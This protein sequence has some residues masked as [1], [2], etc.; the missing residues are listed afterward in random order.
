M[1]RPPLSSPLRAVLAG[2]LALSCLFGALALAAPATAAAP[3]LSVSV[4]V[5]PTVIAGEDADYTIV[6]TNGGDATAHSVT[7]SD[8]FPSALFGVSVTSAPPG[9]TGFPCTLTTLPAGA[10]ATFTV[11]ATVD[12][13]YAGTSLTNTAEISWPSVAPDQIAGSAQGDGDMTVSHLAD[14]AVTATPDRSGVRVGED[15]TWTVVAT[16]EGPSRGAPSLSLPVPAGTVLVGRTTPPGVSCNAAGSCSLGALSVGAQRIIEMTVTV[17]Q[18]YAGTS[19]TLVA[20]GEDGTDTTPNTANDTATSAVDVR[21]LADLTVT[22]LGPTTAV[23]GTSATWSLVVDNHGPSAAPDVSINQQ[24]PAGVTVTAVSG[25]GCNALPCTL[26]T[27]PKDGTATITVTAAI[28]PGF[29]GATLS[30]TATIA[31]PADEPGGAPEGGR[32]STANT[33]ITTSADVRVS[34]A[35]VAAPFVA[36]DTVAWDVVVT[37]DGP[38]TARDLVIVHN[39]PA[40]VSGIALSGPGGVTCPPGGPCTVAAIAPG[41]GNA[42]TIRVT[43]TLA[44]D[45]ADNEISNSVS[46]TSTTTDPD[47]ANNS[48]TA[49]VSVATSADLAVTTSGPSGTVLAGETISWTVTVSNSGPSDARGVVIADPLPSSITGVTVTSANSPCAAVPCTLDTL[50]PG[51]VATLQIS[52]TVAPSYAGA[53]VANTATVSSTTPDS[54]PANNMATAVTGIVRSADLSI[55]KTVDQ[56]PVVPGDDLTYTVTIIN[57]GP[58]QATAVTVT[59]TLPP[60]LTS[61]TATSSIGSCDPVTGVILTCTVAALDPDTS[62][63][64]TITGTLDP[65]VDPGTVTNSATVISAT[66]DPDLSDNTSQVATSTA[67]ADLAVA[68]TA[69]VAEVAP[70][71]AITWTV[72]VS[73]A[74][75]GPARAAVLTDQLPAGV[76]ITSV[77]ISQGACGAAVAG[78]DLTCTLG[79]IAPGTTVTLTVVGA[80]GAA[81]QG[82]LVNTAAAVSRDESDTSDNADQIT[83]PVTVAADLQLA[84]SVAAP[85]VVAGRSTAWTLTVTNAGPAPAT[86]VIVTDVLPAELTEAS[87]DDPRCDLADGVLTCTVGDLAVGE[88]FRVTISGTVA[89]TARAVVVNA[90]SVASSVLDVRPGDNAVQARVAVTAVAPVTV[91]K[92]AADDRIAAGDTTTYTIA[93]TNMGPSTATGVVVVEDLPAGAAVLKASSA[94]YDRGTARWTVGALPPGGTEVLTLK[95]RLEDTG[96]AVNRVRVHYAEDPHGPTARAVV[97]VRPAAGPV[98]AVKPTSATALPATG[99]EDAHLLPWALLLLAA[100]GALVGFS[101]RHRPGEVPGTNG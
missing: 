9:C 51:A 33:V 18:D 44:A 83:I 69:N 31:S 76:D 72:D 30:T 36:G 19:T 41:A 54:D 1:H 56:D 25:A 65:D 48:D 89:P 64:V 24:F 23:A 35:G 85:S 14:V 78:A 27:L 13:N 68:T 6:V 87:A 60:A 47:T 59:D 39:A 86:D 22:N 46:A 2:L 40:G 80:V 90:A 12:P 73:N 34:V 26:S 82:T 71:G 20:T 4:T 93:V 55:L 42:I 3:D 97:R 99:F 81:V 28:A 43:G 88:S 74:G 66:P 57:D 94:T 50:A 95:V 21:P 11:T 49:T 58:S 96:R 92:V 101:R 16:N 15:V 84:Q 61:A 32:S 91:T 53:T 29:T 100:G 63:V 98:G 45:Y 52:G 5:T 70:G 77:H 7:V 8:T 37:N 79:I 75:P 38:S 10:S 67:P 62:M 17:P